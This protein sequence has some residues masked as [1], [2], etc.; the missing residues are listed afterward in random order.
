MTFNSIYPFV[1]TIFPWLNAAP[2]YPHMSGAT[3]DFE[4]K[5]SVHIASVFILIF[6]DGVK[7]GQENLLKADCCFKDCPG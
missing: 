3:L 7:V 2:L 4:N 1:I 6:C 5:C